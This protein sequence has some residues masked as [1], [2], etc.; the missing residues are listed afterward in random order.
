MTPTVEQI[1]ERVREVSVKFKQYLQPPADDA[2]IDELQRESKLR[3]ALSVPA[4]YVHLLR[5]ADGVEWNGAR[6]YAC[7]RRPFVD[8]PDV[9]IPGV[10]EKTASCWHYR[11]QL[12]L[13]N[14][15]GQHFWYDHNV[16][17]YHVWYV[18]DNKPCNRFKTFDELFAFAFDE[19]RL[20][21]PDLPPP[22]D[23]SSFAKGAKKRK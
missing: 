15:E 5:I 22:P 17:E 8:F 16:D 4:R 20:F 10:L 9:G 21:V 6:F 23:W 14:I 13:G 18:S 3:F 2:A 19:S 7:A 1:V 12:M 11:K